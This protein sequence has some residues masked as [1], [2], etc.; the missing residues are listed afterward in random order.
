M[1]PVCNVIKAFLFRRGG[2]G[3]YY[4]YSVGEFMFDPFLACDAYILAH[5]ENGR[6]RL[7]A[8]NVITNPGTCSIVTVPPA[9]TWR[10]PPI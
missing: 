7:D 9:P 6:C 10:T 5:V 3:I 2:S 8:D 4:S 1:M